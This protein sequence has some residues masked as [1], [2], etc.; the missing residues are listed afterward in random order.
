MKSSRIM[1]FLL[2]C[3]LFIV[4]A[5]IPMANAE[6]TIKIGYI[7]VLTGPGAMYASLFKKA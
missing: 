4:F 6:N 2:A 7:G 3:L 5:I 1:P